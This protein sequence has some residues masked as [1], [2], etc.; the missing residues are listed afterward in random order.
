VKEI[1]LGAKVECTDGPAGQATRIIVD[2]GTL[3][4]AHYIVREK[5][6]PHTERIVPVDQIEKATAGMINLRCSLAELAEMKPF[7]ITQYR[8]VDVPT[9]EG[10]MF[11]RQKY[12]RAVMMDVQQEM[13]PQGMVAVRQGDRVEASDG[14]VGKVD[15]LLIDED[16][17]E[18]THF[19]LREGH[20]WGD[21]DVILPVSVVNAV[22]KGTVYLSLDRETIAA[23]LA[24]PARWRA[25]TAEVEL[26]TLT[27]E[28]MDVAKEA[29]KTLKAAAKAEDLTLL[30]VAV[31]VK[32]PEGKT[33]V[34]ETEDVD[35]RHGA[36][37]GAITGGLVGL[38]AGPAGAVLGAVAGAATGGVAAKGIDMGFSDEY[39][40]KLQ[41][42]LQPG[43]SALVALVEAETADKAAETLGQFEGQLLR[44]ALTDETMEQLT[45]EENE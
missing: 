30:N 23:M 8:P 3:Q 39:L 34:T 42:G 5:K 44:Q 4:V 29:L 14:L 11:Y 17:G 16:N 24:I 32:N 15:Q 45:S 27:A 1:H 33:S 38:L 6:R 18:I 36:L 31:L 13:T 12:P 41:K 28:R 2:P 10:D 20:A 26:L 22:R 40:A 37:F 9:Y 21:R 43:S 7:V 19:V 25:Q 35:A